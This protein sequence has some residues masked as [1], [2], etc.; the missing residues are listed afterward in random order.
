MDQPLQPHVFVGTDLTSQLGGHHWTDGSIRSTPDPSHTQAGEKNGP[1]ACA[2]CG[3][4]SKTKCAGCKIVYY[5]GRDCQASAWKAHEAECEVVGPAAKKP[6]PGEERAGVGEGFIARQ[7]VIERLPLGKRIKQYN[8]LGKEYPFQGSTFYNL[9]AAYMER[10]QPGDVELAVQASQRV[11][12]NHKS[13]IMNIAP[14]FNMVPTT[15][16]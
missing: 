5:C 7:Q 11:P 12:E 8:S 6:S 15:A 10:A 16:S 1:T 9:A 4:P 13:Q 14:F 3:K 2:A